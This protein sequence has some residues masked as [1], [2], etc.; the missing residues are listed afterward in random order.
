MSDPS[1]SWSEQQA[2]CSRHVD[3]ASNY[4]CERCGDFLC[5]ECAYPRADAWMCRACLRAS[6]LDGASW[7]ALS[8]AMLGFLSF[9]VPP[10]AF[11]AMLCATVDFVRIAGRSAPREGWRLNLVGLAM[12]VAAT[13]VWIWILIRMLRDPSGTLGG[14]DNV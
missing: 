13:L 14:F 9:C 10:L 11:G 12:A 8:A 5:V 1:E 2:R 3:R 7:L 4:T 6:P